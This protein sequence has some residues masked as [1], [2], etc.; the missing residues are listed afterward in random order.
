MQQILRAL[1]QTPGVI[2]SFI[3]GIDGMLVVSEMNW[4]IDENTVGALAS[5]IIN[6]VEKASTQLDQGPLQ[7]VAIEST[8]NKLFFSPTKSG[9]LVT[10]TEK[11]ANLGLVRLEM[12][13]AVE[14]LNG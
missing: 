12:K 6:T 2:G 11:Q 13:N 7:S 4:H 9:Y 1:N 3:V 8:M 14:Q 5:G 10:V